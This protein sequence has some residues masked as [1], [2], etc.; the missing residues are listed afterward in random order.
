MTFDICA[1]V[2]KRG[3]WHGNGSGND[4]RWWQGSRKQVAEYD[5]ITRNDA[6]FNHFAETRGLGIV[7]RGGGFSV[8]ARH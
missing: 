4:R 7:D 3:W 5:N 6:K 2:K 1:G 8:H